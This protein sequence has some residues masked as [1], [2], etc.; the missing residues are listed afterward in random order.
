MLWWIIHSHFIFPNYH[1]AFENSTVMSASVV[2]TLVLF[3]LVVVNITGNSLV[4]A[5]IRKHR[6]M[7]YLYR[8]ARKFIWLQNFIPSR[9]WAS[10]VIEVSSYW[11]CNSKLKHVAIPGCFGFIYLENLVQGVRDTRSEI[12]FFVFTRI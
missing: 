4:C 12:V 10:Q 11:G 3:T 1:L 2:I 9:F 8:L 7:R 5:I 6:D